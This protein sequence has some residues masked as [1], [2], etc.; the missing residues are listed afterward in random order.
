MSE[1][2][3]TTRARPKSRDGIVI[4]DKMNK[5]VVVA[6]TRRMRH[7]RYGKFVKK[8]LKY[9]AHDERNECQAGDEVRII[10]TRP[11]SKTKRWRVQQILAKAE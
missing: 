4:S 8:T 5:T 6:V 11:L 9:K 10:E 7:P 3:T 1:E 2:V